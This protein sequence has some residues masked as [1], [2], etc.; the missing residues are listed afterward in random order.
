MIG[1][2][3]L[4]D[5]SAIVGEG[6]ILHSPADTE[7]YER[8]YRY[9][10]GHALAIARPATVAELAG[11]VRYCFAHDLKI[12]PQGANTGLVGS[13]T[14][15]ASGG[16]LVVSLD[17]LR[18]V[19]TIDVH[20]RT[21]I[22]RAGTRLSELNRAA[23]LYDLSFPI[24]LGS[25]P[26]LGGMV[27]TNTGGS[28][29]VRYGDV[30]R[31]LLGLEVVLA[32]ADA[33][34][35]TD[36]TGLRKDNSGVDSKQLFV[37]TGG[38]FGIIARVQVELHRIPRQSAVA[39]IEP[40]SHAAIPALVALLESEAGEFLAAFEGMSANAMEAA[41]AHNGRLR[42]PFAGEV[43]P[44]YAVLVELAS[45]V[46][47]E[48]L[49]LSELLTQLLAKAMEGGEPLVKDARFGP[50]EELWA[51]RH[52]I[53]DGVRALGAIVAFDIS[54]PRSQ[55]PALR[56]DLIGLLT[57]AY[58]QLRICDF[59]HCGDGGD[60]FNL[61]W[62]SGAG[63]YDAP[64]VGRVRELIYDRVVRGYGGS[65]SAEHGVGPHNATYYKRY[66]SAAERQLA[67]RLKQLC[68]PKGILGTVDFG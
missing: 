61:V 41:F 66:A 4:R 28:R 12:V 22:V 26:S 44:P 51:I 13:S 30:Q 63:P 40:T 6:A 59:G 35:L 42:N 60:H 48:Y 54:V 18:G 8:G 39:L 47:A 20:N 43:L 55:L 16:Q 38:S 37:G 1:A 65:F 29:L 50:S 27:A 46:G 62:P 5:L 45:T 3:L 19:E 34:I 17:R 11:L 10:A 67:G 31:N 32:D 52:S 25:D 21:A 15:D 7:Q 64:V 33:T 24:D 56:A 14:P 58:P 36:L 68:D 2:G 9:G 57:E 23:G 53:S 49:D